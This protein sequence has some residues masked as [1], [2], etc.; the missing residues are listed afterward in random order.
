MLDARRHA[1]LVFEEN[2][3]DVVLESRLGVSPR[4]SVKR[5]EKMVR[6]PS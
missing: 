1:P 2:V 4:D 5:G 6:D 3:L